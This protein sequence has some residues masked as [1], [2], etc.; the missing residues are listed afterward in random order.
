[1]ALGL[2]SPVWSRLHLLYIHGWG[3]SQ[4]IH[5]VKKYLSKNNKIT[6]IPKQKIEPFLKNPQYYYQN[7]SPNH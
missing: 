4:N 1:M 7:K 5:S 3:I 2:E 6:R